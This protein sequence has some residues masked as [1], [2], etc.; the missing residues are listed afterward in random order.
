MKQRT[1]SLITVAV[2]LSISISCDKCK[3]IDCV[4]GVC[5]EGV[6]DCE[7]GYTGSRCQTEINPQGGGPG[8]GTGGGPGGGSCDYIQYT[9]SA[10]CNPGSVPVPGG[11]CPENTPYLAE[12]CGICA[13][14][15]E[16]AEEACFGSGNVYR[17]NTS[18]GGGG[19]STSGYNCVS[20]TCVSVNS[21]AT[22]S[23][24]SA[25]NSNCSSPTG[26]LMVWNSNPTP[27]PA[28]A[29]STI[30]VYINGSYAGGLGN[31]YTSAPNCGASAAITQTLPAGSHTVSASCGSAGWG[32]NT[33]TVT[34][35]GCFK[36]ELN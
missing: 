10:N 18:G 25:C 16:G 24:L 27:C 22:Y 8:G 6:C 14:T 7:P 12:D 5:N 15:C 9:G 1:V 23:S 3:D 21:G 2:V 26:Q 35:G 28:G 33:Y 4:Y 34:A 29:G 17:A 31:Y 13:A 30:S 11:C 36:L 32:P 19:G 20:G